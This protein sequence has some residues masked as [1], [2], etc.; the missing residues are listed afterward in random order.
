VYPGF[1]CVWDMPPGL[2]RPGS[3]GCLSISVDRFQSAY[4]PN[5]TSCITET[6]TTLLAIFNMHNRTFDPYLAAMHKILVSVVIRGHVVPQIGPTF[7]VQH[8]KCDQKMGGLQ[9]LLPVCQQPILLVPASA[10]W[11]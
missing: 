2:P 3:A 1:T 8:N 5:S 6:N 7:A 11:N 9:S 4:A 10:R